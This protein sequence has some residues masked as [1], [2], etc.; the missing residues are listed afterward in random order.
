[1]ADPNQLA[2]RREA[3]LELQAEAYRLRKKRGAGNQPDSA[4]P[5]P[6]DY[7]EL[8]KLFTQQYNLERG[9]EILQDGLVVCEPNERLYGELVFALEQANRTEDAICLAHRAKELFPDARY[10]ELWEA[11]MLPVLYDTEDAMQ[12][13]RARYSSGLKGLTAGLKL[14][15]PEDCRSAFDA[16]SQ[17]LNFYLAYQGENDRELQ[18]KYGQ[19]IHRIMA[20]AWP[21]WVKPLLMPRISSGGKIRVGYI[22]AHFR[23]HSVLKMMMGWLRE[24]D[25]QGFEIFTYHNGRTLDAVTDEVRRLSDHFR[26]IPGELEPI[27]RAV[28]EDNLHIAVYLDVRHKR[29]TMMSALR[30]APIQCVGYAYA[31]T[32]GLPTLDYYLSSEMI[33]PENGQDHYTEHLIRLPG[34]GICYPKPEIGRSLLRKSRSDFGIGEDRTVYLCCQSL[35]K[36]LPQHDDLFVRIAK[37]LPNSQ[38]V[39]LAFND[40]VAK[41][42]RARLQCAFEAEGLAGT[43]YCLVLPRLDSLDYSNLTLLSDVFLDSLGYSGCVTTIDAIACG[44]PIVTLPGKFMRGRHSYGFLAQL[45]ITDTIACDKDEYVGI[46]VRLGRDCEWRTQIIERMKANY[47]RLYSDARCVR[48]LEVFFRSAVSQSFAV[49]SSAVGSS[50]R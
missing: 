36:Y 1:M 19:F 30:L 47:A 22:S 4:R 29:M 2:R 18:E 12:Y 8:A 43:D 11:L 6:T 33:E 16:I 9:I 46:A 31:T 26:H 28:S 25:R 20:A 14:D 50:I 34:I 27:C 7:I 10:F 41:D 32:S 37:V 13:Y 24:H 39:F 21:Q 42:F 3:A 38:F 44:L 45:G 23:D 48:A 15:T 40:M 35:F 17:H 49:S 5:D